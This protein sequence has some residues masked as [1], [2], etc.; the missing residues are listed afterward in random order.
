MAIDP[1]CK[2]EVDEKTAKIKSEY[3]EKTYYFCAPGCKKEFDDNP[4]KYIGKVEK[5]QPPLHGCC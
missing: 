3:K 1:I 2:M 4:E 5:R